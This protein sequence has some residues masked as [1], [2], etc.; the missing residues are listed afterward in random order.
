MSI[1]SSVKKDAISKT[2]RK[3]IRKE[4]RRTAELQL[5]EE[6]E[7]RRR[8]IE[9][10]R[11]KVVEIEKRLELNPLAKLSREDGRVLRLHF[12]LTGESTT[13]PRTMAEA[14]AQGWKEWN[15]FWV[16]SESKR[17]SAIFWNHAGIHLDFS[18]SSLELI[19][20]TPF[21]SNLRGSEKEENWGWTGAY[22]YFTLAMIGSYFGMVIV[23]NL[24]GEWKYPSRL[25]RTV[26]S[27]FLRYPWFFDRYLIGCLPI[28]VF[29]LALDHL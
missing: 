19:D 24:G 4:Y 22:H 8:L 15:R 9:E 18:P 2:E 21:L 20:S 10:T 28:D 12:S 13:R 27:K 29:R 14:K 23:R 3:R 16:I 1:G 17:L 25:L 7:E 11:P 5:Q 26:A 6:V